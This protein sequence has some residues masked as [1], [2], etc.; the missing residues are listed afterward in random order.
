MASP[1]SQ[2]D[3]GKPPPRGAP[4]DG[5]GSRDAPPSPWAAFHHRDFSVIWTA[6]L[7]SN[8]GGW[9]YSASSGWLMTT[10][11]ADPLMVSLV[12]VAASLPLF[13]FALPAGALADILDRRRFLICAEVYIAA[14][15]LLFAIFVSLNLITP[16]TL[17]LFVL[18]IETGAAATSPAWQAIVSQLV[19]RQDLP[20]AIAIN[21]VGVNISR[22]LG[23]ALGG[24][25]TAIL[26][27]AAPFWINAFSNFGTISALAWWRAP[28][29]RSHLPAERFMSAMRT[30]VRYARYNHHLRATL[31]RAIAFFLFAS[32]YWA[33]LPVVTRSQIGGGARLYGFLLG[34]IGASAIAGAFA[35]PRLKAKLGPNRVVAAGSAATAVALVLFGLSRQP[36]TAIAACVIAGASWI[37]VLANLNV[38]AQLALPEWVR[39]RGLAIYV[40]AFFGAM[41]LGSA[42]WGQVARMAGTPLTHFL[43]AAGALLAIPLTWRWKLHSAAGVDLS[44][45]SQWPAP[46]VSPDV[47][48]DAG[49]ALVTIEYRIDT[50]NREP[51]LRALE[52]LS[53]ERRR[54]GAY[55]WGAFEDT[56]EPCRYVETFLVESWLEHLRQH[57][58]VT[59]ADRVLQDHVNRYLTMPAKT[60]H[61]ISAHARSNR[62]EDPRS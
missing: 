58:R 22:A 29:E 54:D 50:A 28:R 15:G 53:R 19:P 9:M 25:L 52:R 51:F 44:P 55:A 46:I 4:L 41:T 13:L 31:V 23:P 3:P 27:I 10:L 45:S 32:C 2:L 61:L 42:L 59:H 18:L 56:A 17:L 60:T 47:P 30:G 16:T 40:T 26:G 57:E 5:A 48:V 14:A 34:V 62:D 12:Q 24:L 1:S 43:A 20:S 21:S 11:D 33:L 37:A 39:G 35:L 7:V 38:S 49:P 8:I 6:T 36:G